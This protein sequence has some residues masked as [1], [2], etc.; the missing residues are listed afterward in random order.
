LI[1]ADAF[2]ELEAEINEATARA[3]RLIDTTDGQHFTVRPHPGSWSAAECLAHLTLSS[4][5]FVPV[6]EQAITQARSRGLQ[7]DKPPKMDLLGQ[8]LRW[9]LEP[10]IRKKVATSAAL[11][12]QSTRARA[13]ALAEF[14][15][16]QSQLL[17]KVRDARGLNLT[18]MKIVSPFDQRVRYNLYSA[19]KIVTAHERRHLWQAEQAVQTLMANY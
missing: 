8:V 15:S 7:S 16:L 12:P 14:T 19:F 13:E 17:A 2:D 10:P 9:F 3:R 5:S 1:V 11:V 18:K 6:L 4:K